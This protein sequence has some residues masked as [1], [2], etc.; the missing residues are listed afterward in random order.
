MYRKHA[1]ANSKDSQQAMAV[2]KAGKLENNSDSSQKL[3]ASL[4]CGGLWSLTL[5]AQKIFGKLESLFRQLTPIVNL[6]GINLSG[7]TQKAITVSDKLSNFDLMVA[8][9]I[10]KPGNHVR[11]DVLFS[12]VKLYV[13]VHAFS[14]SKDEIQR[15][16]HTAIKTNKV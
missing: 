2:L 5:P 9:A 13:R 15:H 4:N 8:E 12:T 3:I 6:Q 1:K 10:I 7:I 16:K 14:M 11:K